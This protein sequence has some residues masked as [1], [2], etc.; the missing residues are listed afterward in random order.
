MKIEKA[1]EFGVIQ[2]GQNIILTIFEVF[3]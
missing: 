1:H 2:N 3:L